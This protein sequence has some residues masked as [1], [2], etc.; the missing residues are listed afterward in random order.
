MVKNYLLGSIR[1][2]IQY[3]YPSEA[4]L[5]RDNPD[6]EKAYHEYQEMYRI[7]RASARQFLQGEWEEIRFQSP[8]LNARLFQIAQWYQLRETW[9]REPCNIL[10]VTADVIFVRPVEI[11]DEFDH[12]MLFN[13]TDPKVHPDLCCYEDGQGHY[14]NDSVAYF[15]HTMDPAVWELGERRMADWFTHAQAHWDCGQ[16]IHNHMYWSQP[17]PPDQR[18]RPDLNFSAH[19][20]RVTDPEVIA[21][22]ELW[23]NRLPWDQARI[24]HF[25]GSRGAMRTVDIMRKLANMHGIDHA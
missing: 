20:L 7:S 1:P 11:F 4:T 14:F 23:N 9:F 2:V 6:R 19:N 22:H 18:L 8:V 10:S 12:M 24:M 17:I 13:Y 3:W 21:Y 5:G 15:P 25:A 16:L